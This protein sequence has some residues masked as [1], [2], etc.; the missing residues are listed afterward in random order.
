MQAVGCVSQVGLADS[1]NTL[2]VSLPG[3]SEQRAGDR[4]PQLGAGK[5]MVDDAVK[6]GLSPEG[7]P[8]ILFK[9][10]RC[11]VFV[12]SL[13]VKAVPLTICPAFGQL[14]SEKFFGDTVVWGDCVTFDVEPELGALRLRQLCEWDAHCPGQA[15]HRVGSDQ[16]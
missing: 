1:G 16:G 2:G 13:E 12:K 4:T 11:H 5:A 14:F 8:A 3:C 15:V 9:H 7:C 6:D 10:H